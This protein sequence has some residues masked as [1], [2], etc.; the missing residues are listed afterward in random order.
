MLHGQE[1]KAQAAT[2]MPPCVSVDTH[3]HT[4]RVVLSYNDEYL[5]LNMTTCDALRC[6]NSTV[7]TLLF[8]PVP[9]L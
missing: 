8:I 2:L 5:I 6:R 7:T 3:T 4:Q 1:V 9:L